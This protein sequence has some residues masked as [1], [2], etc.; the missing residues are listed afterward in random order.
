MSNHSH[1][2]MKFLME[3]LAEWAAGTEELLSKQDF[4]DQPVET[5]DF[6]AMTPEELEKAMSIAIEY[7]K[8]IS[9]DPKL[10]KNIKDSKKI[11]LKDSKLV[12]DGK[13]LYWLTQGKV[14]KSWPATSG[15]HQDLILDEEG[16]EIGLTIMKALKTAGGKDLFQVRREMNDEIA[17]KRREFHGRMGHAQAFIHAAELVDLVESFWEVDYIQKFRLKAEP[18][19]KRKSKTDSRLFISALGAVLDRIGLSS[20]SASDINAGMRRERS[21]VSDIGPIPEGQYTII[22]NLQEAPMKAS[23]GAERA[24]YSAIKVYQ[25]ANNINWTP[26]QEALAKELMPISSLSQASAGVDREDFGAMNLALNILTGEEVPE[27]ASLL[28]TIPWGNY[29]LKISRI[30][31]GAAE[32]SDE[33]QKIYKKRFGFYIHGG[34]LPGSSGCI[35]L[36]SYMDDFAQFWSVAGVTEIEK[37][38][39]REGARVESGIEIPLEVKYMDEEKRNLLMKNKIAREYDHFVFEPQ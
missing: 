27:R 20:V 37:S 23:P 5:V 3:S 2:K 36:G 28:A 30:P 9:S 25:D 1:K 24:L 33:A 17:S 8:Q 7:Q 11:T 32:L 22:H 4:D 15:H 31:E 39:G 16:L 10:E 26:E 35:D 38:G 19:T 18:L 6:A 21:G 29:R 34:S 12:F 14:F 13:K